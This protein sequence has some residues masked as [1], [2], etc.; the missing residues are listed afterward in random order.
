MGI[1]GVYQATRPWYDPRYRAVSVGC[2]HGQ[3]VV[4]CWTCDLD[5]ICLFKRW[6]AFGRQA[7]YGHWIPPFDRRVIHAL[8]SPP[9]FNDATLSVISVVYHWMEQPI[10][11]TDYADL[12]SAIWTP[13]AR[14]V[15]RISHSVRCEAPLHQKP[16]L[17]HF[18]PGTLCFSAQCS[19][20]TVVILASLDIGIMNFIVC[21]LRLQHTFWVRTFLFSLWWKFQLSFIVV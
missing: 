16:F 15:S 6:S 17:S 4:H 9:P 13:A 2:F 8:H 3:P 10:T 5:V 14:E 7:E 12:K 11:S 20:D 21:I 19:C 1:T 18:K